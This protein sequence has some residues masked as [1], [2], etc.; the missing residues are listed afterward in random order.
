MSLYLHI[1]ELQRD[2]T[3]ENAGRLAVHIEYMVKCTDTPFAEWLGLAHE[4]RNIA[5]APSGKRKERLLD[6]LW[7][8][9]IELRRREGL[10]RYHRAMRREKDRRRQTHH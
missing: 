2:V 3:E 8:M 6:T 9:E 7:I 5:S 10:E 4:A 1:K